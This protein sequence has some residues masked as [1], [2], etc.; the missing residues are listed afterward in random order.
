MEK[1]LGRLE[2]EKAGKGKKMEEI[3]G[4]K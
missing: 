1:E 2:E 4:L 3:G